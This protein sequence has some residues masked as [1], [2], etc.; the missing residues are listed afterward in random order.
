MI[1]WLIIIIMWLLP[2]SALAQ[3]RITGRVVNLED[4]KPVA[5]ASVFL[6]NATA[7]AKTND[8]GTYT[9]ANVRG[10]QYEL[11]VSMVGYANYRQTIMVNNDIS[12]PDIEIISKAI[13]LREVRIHPDKNWALHYDMFRREFLGES[14]NA[15]QCKI[16]NPKVLDFSYDKTTS[17]LSASS[18]DFVD[19]ENKALGYRVRY[20]LANFTKNYSKG[21]LYYEGSAQF[22]NLKGNKSQLKKWQKNRQ[23]TYEGSSMHFLRTIIA[24]QLQQEGFKVLRLT[25][26][27]NPE[28]RGGM[29]NR[30]VE[31][32][33]TTPLEINDFAIRTDKNGIYALSFKDCLYIMYAKPSV[34]NGEIKPAPL[35]TIS[36]ATIGGPYAYF[37]NNGII[38]N[39]QSVTFE[40]SLGESRLAELLPVDYEPMQ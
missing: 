20:L 11:V 7:G 16:L 2:Y 36:I 19:V 40:G 34:T 33:L 10:G 3:Y 12:L 29:N 15:K 9:I 18:S 28:Y 35:Y 23:N 37:D 4:K 38:I 1:K 30:Y 32:L 22:E 31:T 26:K 8:D 39:P 24:N 25:R 13:E 17:E 6:S 27:P 14:E 21:Y 5:N